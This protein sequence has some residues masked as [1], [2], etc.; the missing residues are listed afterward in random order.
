MSH[1]VKHA[2]RGWMVRACSVMLLAAATPVDGQEAQ[3]QGTAADKPYNPPPAFSSS[4]IVEFTLHAPFGKLRRDR[5][6]ETE[7]RPAFIT[8]NDHTTGP[9]RVPVRVRTRGIWRK[10]NCQIPPLMFNFTKDS[11]KGTVFGRLDRVRFSFH[12]RDIDEYEQYVL[13]EHQLYRVQRLLTPLAFAVRLVRVTYVDSDNNDTLS[14]RYGFLQ[15]IDEEFAARQKMMLVD[16]QG[17]GP[18]DLDPYESAFFGV[19]QYFVGN[20]DYSIRALHNVVLLL[21]P[22]YHIPVARDFDW[23]GA[24]NARYAKPNPVLKIR[25]VAQ[26]VMRG[27]CAPAEEYEKVFQ[28]FREK[29]DAIYALYSDSLNAAMKPQVVKTTL[30][31]F[32]D[33]YETINDPKKAQREIVEACLAGSA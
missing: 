14:T 24:V 17:A 7:Y 32:D 23:S 5:K 19:L 6:A 26:R 12:C 2:A 13:Q 10:A 31:Y 16:Q 3:P 8:Y 30:E 9:Q 22:P 11:T 1:N 21:R 4:S 20:S 28:L 29:K 25:H 18:S 27:Y 15:E 33:F